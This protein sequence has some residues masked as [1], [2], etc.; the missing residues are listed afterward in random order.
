MKIIY[1]DGKLTIIKFVFFVISLYCIV[2]TNE[3]SNQ[4]R[5]VFNVTATSKAFKT[6]FIADLFYNKTT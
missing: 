4:K 6:Y 5:H 2:N 3:A 1:F